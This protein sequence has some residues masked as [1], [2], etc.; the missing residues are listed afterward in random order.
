MNVK[1]FT[2]FQ[3]HLYV[4][5][6]IEPGNAAMRSLRVYSEQS[7]VTRIETTDQIEHLTH[8][9]Y[10]HVRSRF[11]WLGLKRDT[12]RCAVA[13]PSILSYEIES[14]ELS[15]ESLLTVLSQNEIEPLAS[16]PKHNGRSPEHR[17][18]VDRLH[19]VFQTEL[20]NR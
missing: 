16:V 7:L 12:N 11:V 6:V 14:L 1:E 4:P 10:I 19:R 20:T 3:T 8:R 5:E 13:F 9:C 2:G 17:G 18:A 15:F